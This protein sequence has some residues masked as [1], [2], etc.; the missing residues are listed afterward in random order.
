MKINKSKYKN[1]ALRWKDFGSGKVLVLLHGFM[2]TSDIW[3]DFAG[4]LSENYR[5]I[6]IDL[7]GHGKSENINGIHTMDEMARAVNFILTQAKINECVIIGHSMG[8]YVALAFA[9]LYKN[10]VNGLGLFHSTATCDTEEAKTNR[11]RTIEIV[12]KNRISFISS[13]I[14][15]L[16]APS[17]REIFKK[18]IIKLEKSAKEMSAE[19]IIA[20]LSGMKIRPD[21]KNIIENAKY[22]VLFIIGK[23]D[24]RMPYIK[25]LEQASSAKDATILLLGD[26][27][28]MGY[29]E[30][31]NKTLHC[32]EYFLKGIYN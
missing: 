8:G 22:P 10:K 17:N 29:L 4:E 30:S 25:I 2:E 19:G 20:A 18:E 1:T 5:I 31:R 15:D 23:L 12:R 7:P 24:S 28:H 13:F 6:T 21:R 16:F 11:E 9:E 3:D 14:P 27:G 26:T 32:I